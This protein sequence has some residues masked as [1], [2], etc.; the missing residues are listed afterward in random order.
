MLQT[1]YSIIELPLFESDSQFLGCGNVSVG[2]GI[3]VG[4]SG[5]YNYSIF[6]R[7]SKKLCRSVAR[8]AFKIKEIT[9]AI[10]TLY[11]KFLY[12]KSYSLNSRFIPIHLDCF[13]LA[14]IFLH[15]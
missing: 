2:V 3:T 13:I 6:S 9:F 10:K 1:I 5:N 8:E 12:L 14:C 4:I 15:S 11:F 7:S